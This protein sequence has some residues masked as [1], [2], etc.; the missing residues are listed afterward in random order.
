MTFRPGHH[1]TSHV[2]SHV[3]S[4]RLVGRRVAGIRR[5]GGHP[6]A[7]TP[8]VGVLVRLAQ[9]PVEPGRAFVARLA[10]RAVDRAAGRASGMSTL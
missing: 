7:T 9:P 4:R 2:T 8:A 1:V 10:R 5:V 3:A 6:A